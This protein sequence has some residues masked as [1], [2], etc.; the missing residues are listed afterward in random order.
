MK[1][2]IHRATII[3]DGESYV[4]SILTDGER[5]AKIYRGEKIYKHE[6]GTRI[7]T[8]EYWFPDGIEREADVVIPA[9][10][11]LLLPGCIDDQVHFREPGLT[12]KATIE[13]ESEVVEEHT[14]LIVASVS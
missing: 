10:G 3:N 5:I 2:L 8:G 7:D 13:T 4:G 14:L 1:Q 9:E 12:H 11:L 6:A